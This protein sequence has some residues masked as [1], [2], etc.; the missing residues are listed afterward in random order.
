MCQFGYCDFE[1]GAC[2]A[3]SVPFTVLNIPEEGEVVYVDPLLG[4][5]I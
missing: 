5:T 3:L 4:L 2:S 1:A